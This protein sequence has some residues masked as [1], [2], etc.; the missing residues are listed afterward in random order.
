MAAV[1]A[2]VALTLAIGDLAA[3]ATVTQTFIGTVDSGPLAGEVGTGSFT[4]DSDDVSDGEDILRLNPDDHGLEVELDFLGQS[5][6]ETNDVDYPLFPEL[7]F[8]SGEP[9]VL[10]FNVVE[11][12]SLNPTEIEEPGVLSF[13]TRDLAP[14]PDADYD[15]TTT[16]DVAM[17]PEPTTAALAAPLALLAGFRRPRRRSGASPG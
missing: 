8:I 16:I 5:F 12:D 17:I 3:A 11:G 9:A 2:A 13:Q 4:Y 10:D 7:G 1:A 14:T 15:F 6:D